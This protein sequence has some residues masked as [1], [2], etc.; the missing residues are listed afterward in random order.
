MPELILNQV[1]QKNVAKLD[2]QIL[3]FG[4]FPSVIMGKFGPKNKKIWFFSTY[5]ESIDFYVFKY[6]WNVSKPRKTVFVGYIQ[7]A[8]M[9]KICP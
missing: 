9:L 4:Y 5:F 7:R 3:L 8:K 1:Q 2:P 6:A